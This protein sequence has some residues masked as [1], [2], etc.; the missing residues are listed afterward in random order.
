MRNRQTRKGRYLV[1]NHQKYE[2]DPTEVFY[3]SGWEY[4]LLRYL[5]LHPDV[6]SF[7][8][9]TVI[10]PYLSPI[11]GRWHRY[12][13]DAKATFRDK[14]GNIKTVLI[15]VKPY[16]QTLP[17]RKNGGLTPAYLEAVKTWGVNQAKWA[18]A[19][20]LCRDKGWQ[21]MIMT[22]KDGLAK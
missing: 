19:E 20:A 1:E 21:F 7:S 11:D 12:F 18:A 22:E 8:S 5:D 6:I 2:G 3:R 10:V 17:P 13:V 16:A 4:K 9:E 14:N 15:E